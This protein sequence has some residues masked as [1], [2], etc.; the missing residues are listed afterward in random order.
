[1]FFLKKELRN[2]YFFFSPTKD[3]VNRTFPQT[4]GNT[5]PLP[6]FFRKKGFPS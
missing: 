4:P 1:M 5:R 3:V 2:Y 6:L